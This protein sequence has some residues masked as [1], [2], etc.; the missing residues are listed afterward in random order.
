MGTYIIIGGDGKEYGPIAAADLRQWVVEGR[1][2]GLSL[3]KSPSDAEFR[4]LEKFPE[5]ADLFQR[6]R[7]VPHRPGAV[8]QRNGRGL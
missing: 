5:F 2:N 4:P 7:S 8:R 3:A 1:L 6:G